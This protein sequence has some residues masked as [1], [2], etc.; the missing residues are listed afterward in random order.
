M[1]KVL[2]LLKESLDN[3]LI[4]EVFKTMLGFYCIFTVSYVLF[5]LPQY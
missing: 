5:F 2:G 1:F 4:L 3:N